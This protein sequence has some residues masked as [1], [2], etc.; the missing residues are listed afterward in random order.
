[1]ST[2]STY[3]VTGMNCGHCEGA[4]RTEV[5]QIPGVTAVDV[6]AATGRLGVTATDPV[7]DSAVIAAVSE[8]GYE[9]ARS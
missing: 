8:A 3:S 4:I 7:D 9:A 5:L 6:S 2:T 1:M